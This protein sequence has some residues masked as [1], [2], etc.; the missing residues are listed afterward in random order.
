MLSIKLLFFFS[1]FMIFWGMV[2]YPISLIILNRIFFLKRK[3][4]K[5]YEVKPT[6]TVMVVA[7]NEEKVIYQKLEN[8]IKLDYPKE[9]LEI[10]V[11]SDN[12][13]DKTNLLVEKFKKNNPTVNVRLYVAKKHLGKTNA[14]NEAQK[15]VNSEILVMTDANSMLASD[16]VTEL[17]ASF[18]ESNIAY[19]CGKLI[20]INKDNNDIANSEST[21]WNLDLKMRE[22]E[23]R[24]QTITAGN[25]ALYACRNKDYIEFEA[26]RSHDLAMPIFYGLQ[27]KRAIMNPDA[28]VF[29]KAGETKE[30]E[31]K[32]KV[33]MNRNNLKS[34]IP[35]FKIFNVIKYKWF[36]YFYFGH[37]TARYSLWI[38]HVL[39]FISNIFI[40]NLNTISYLTFY[41]Q[42]LCFI[43]FIIQHF[44]NTKIK[45]LVLINYYGMIIVA[46]ALGAFKALTGKTKATWDKAESTR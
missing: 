24:I 16:A 3:N 30:D 9:M 43:L 31:F 45:F 15:E 32:R 6:V 1:I 44:T 4:L 11:T 17:V 46:Q 42:I 23:S 14:Q 27:N 5:N 35:T 18:S 25:G 33:R 2:G 21:Y 19:V 7:H 39:L 36:S 28:K 29:E 41:V 10:L 26:I 22:I 13:T 37:R 40:L 8:L 38:M 20:Y 12:S 34:I